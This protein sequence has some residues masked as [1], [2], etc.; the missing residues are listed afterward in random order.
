M[1]ECRVGVIEMITMSEELEGLM[2]ELT[3]ANAAAQIARLKI[4]AILEESMTDEKV[5]IYEVH[6]NIEAVQASYMAE[7]KAKVV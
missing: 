2:R 3:E 1:K 4:R 6:K 5:L 7:A